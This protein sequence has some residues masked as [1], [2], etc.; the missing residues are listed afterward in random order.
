MDHIWLQLKK[1]KGQISSNWVKELN[2]SQ[3]RSTLVKMGKNESKSNCV[4][5][6]QNWFMSVQISGHCCITQGTMNEC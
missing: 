5:S 6:G 1:K 2:I 4:N 3:N